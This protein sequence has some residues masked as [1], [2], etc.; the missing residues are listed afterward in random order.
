MAEQA[1]EVPTNEVQNN[2]SSPAND[3]K[4]MQEV[5]QYVRYIIIYLSVFMY[6]SFLSEDL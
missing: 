1:P 4:N 3:P 5:T 2:Y 6:I